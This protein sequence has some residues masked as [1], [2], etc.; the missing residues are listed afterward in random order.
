V[1]LI[2]IRKEEVGKDGGVVL[3]DRRACHILTVLKARKGQELKVGLLNGRRGTGVI[4]SVTGGEVMLKCTFTEEPLQSSSSRLDLLLALP[5]P[6]VLKRL[7]APLASL[8]IRRIFLTNAA[9]VEREYFDTH[10]LDP[11]R[12][13]ALLIEGLEQ[14]SDTRLPEVSVI[15]RLKPFIEDKLD[16]IC[17]EG[18]RLIAHPGNG[19]RLSKLPRKSGENV[20]IAIGPEGGWTDFELNLFEQ[21]G[22]TQVTLGA[23]KL[24]TDT[25]CI[26]LMSVISEWMDVNV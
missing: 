11:G 13:E 12:Y 22:F 14:A 9:K 3:T 25:A 5:R 10:W 20:L 21:H 23:R 4:E 8:G 1:N 26:A 15:R 6:K 24:R 17:R 19:L 16:G 2:L 7:W 18:K